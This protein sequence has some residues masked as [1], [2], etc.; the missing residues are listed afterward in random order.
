MKYTIEIDDRLKAGKGLVEVAKKLAEIHKSIKVKKFDKE[1]M[2]DKIFGQ[3]MEE[4]MKSGI[5]N[6]KEVEEFF[7]ELGIEQ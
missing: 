5:A 2:E 4:S 7:K 3:M 6:K 1:A